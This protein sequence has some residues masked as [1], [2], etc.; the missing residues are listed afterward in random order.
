MILL[1]I[2]FLVTAC[3]STSSKTKKPNPALAG[4]YIAQAQTLEKK[5][6]LPAALEQ[7]KL[8]LT[9]DPENKQA[10]SNQARLKQTL[11]KLAD[12]RYKLGMKYHRQGKYGLARKEFL[13]SLKYNP[14]HEKASKMLVSRKPN[15]IPKYVFHTVQPGE[16]LSHIAKKYYGDYRKYKVIA[17]F[18]NLDDAAMVKPGQR[19]M[20]PDDNSGVLS[21]K[22]AQDGRE[23]ASFVWHTIQP[24]ESI[25]QLA[26]MYYGDYKLFHAIAQYN[27][28]VDATQVKVGQ[29]IKI[30]K[31]AGVPFHGPDDASKPEPQAVA[32]EPVLMQPEMSGE[33]A[34]PETVLDEGTEVTGE[35]YPE[36]APEPLNGE[37]QVMGYREAGITLFNEGKYEDAVFELNKA[38]EAMPDDASTRLYLARAYFEN[39]KS[40]FNQQDFKAAQE[41][42][43]SSLQYNPGCKECSGYIDRSKMGPL[44]AH[45][46]KGITL[47][48]QKRYND[49]IDEFMQFLHE[50]PEDNEIRSYLA[51]AYFEQGAAA[52]QKNDFI[53][54][55]ND[56]EKAMVYDP[57]CADCKAY[58]TRSIN[59]YKESHYNR[60]IIFFGK[61]QLPEAIAEWEKVY[62]ID[63]SYKDVEHNLKRAQNLLDKLEQIKKSQ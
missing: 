11:S 54:A 10:M 26:K 7:Y 30:P 21:V 57:D 46:T 4:Q 59:S 9:V 34:V 20:I 31:L 40:L 23:K 5:G 38:V 14:D 42:F 12:E 15:K 51:K 52:Y 62:E 3:V 49:A 24:G 27:G 28:M 33:S 50:R 61:E 17:R 25:A 19:I 41:S 60:G 13:I 8:A 63:P 39:G 29:K 55:R 53:T 18:N 2:A 43:E 1:W 48:Q 32:M 36:T 37:E 35:S 56:F 47:L 45:R 6:D 44:L 22:S 16:S 58:I